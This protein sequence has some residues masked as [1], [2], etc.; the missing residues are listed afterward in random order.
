MNPP[1][2][3]N[4]GPPV[5]PEAIALAESAGFARLVPEMQAL[6]RAEEIERF[7]F[8]VCRGNRFVAFDSYLKQ[9]LLDAYFNAVGAG[10]TAT[11]LR[12]LDVLATL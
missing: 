5:W 11:A 7:G 4:S 9:D 2:I 12:I 6:A 8:P 3:P 10:R 1:P